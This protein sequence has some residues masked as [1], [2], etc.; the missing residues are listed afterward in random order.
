MPYRV[1]T[2]KNVRPVYN[3]ITGFY[4]DV[5]TL[6][7]RCFRQMFSYERSYNGHRSVFFT[8]IYSLG[9]T[10]FSLTV[11]QVLGLPKHAHIRS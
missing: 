4:S 8:Y 7:R 5:H 9:Y 2:V 10:S 1:V 11:I 6:Y 3:M